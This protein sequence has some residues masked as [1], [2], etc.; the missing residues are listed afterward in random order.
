MSRSQA[1]GVRG[2]GPGIGETAEVPWGAQGAMKAR[3]IEREKNRGKAMHNLE[4]R[5]IK[6][7]D[8]WV[9]RAGVR[10]Q[11]TAPTQGA[12]LHVELDPEQALDLLSELLYRRQTL[13]AGLRPDI[14][15]NAFP[16]PVCHAPIQMSMET[17]GYRGSCR[18]CQREVILNYK[19]QV[20]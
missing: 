10:M 1:S 2:W 5:R 3:E 8:V 12:P 16:C 6:N 19:G 17:T 15:L 20:M 11:G 14:D 4:P 7:L 9:S 13:L 18:T